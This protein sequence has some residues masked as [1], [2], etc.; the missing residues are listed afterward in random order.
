[1]DDETSIQAANRAENLLR[2]H[3]FIPHT[4]AEAAAMAQ[5]NAV[6]A[7]AAEVAQLKNV[8]IDLSRRLDDQ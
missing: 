6:L 5:A 3:E 7:L 4:T 8:V 1:M 2:A